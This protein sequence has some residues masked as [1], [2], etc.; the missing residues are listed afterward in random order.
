MPSQ[1][2]PRSERL[3][4]LIE[5]TETP[6]LVLAALAVALY[7]GDLAGFWAERH[8]TAVTTPLAAALDVVFVVDVVFKA[9]VLGR[10][11][12]KTGWFFIDLVSALPVV[13]T[14][15]G[16][17]AALRGLRFVRG[18]RVFRLLRSLRSLRALRALPGLRVPAAQADAPESATFHRAVTVAVAIYVALLLALVEAPIGDPRTAELY[19]VVGSL[20]GTALVLAIVRYQLPDVST[21]QVRTLLNVALPE[22]VAGRLMKD[23]DAYGHS[24]RGPATVVFC[25]LSGFTASVEA[26][27]GDLDAL[28]KN[29][30]AC[31]DAVVAVHLEHDLIVDK[32]IGDAVMS[33]RGGDMVEGDPEDHACRVVRASVQSASA[34]ARVQNPWFRTMKIGGAS[35]PDILIGTFGTSRRLSYTV[36]GDRVNLASRLE[37][38][39]G[40]FGVA[41]LFDE[42]TRDLA[43]DCEGIAWRR[44]GRIRVQGKQE[45]ITVF[46]ALDAASDTGW[47]AAYEAAVDRFEARDFAAAR[48]GFEVALAARGGEDGPSRVFVG[49][50]ERLARDGVPAGWEPILQ[51][52]K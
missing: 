47:V 3:P 29:L 17:P 34:L 22:Q 6:V 46:E 20:L 42:T 48:A 30:E 32:F 41:N 31:L 14:I 8:L 5:R 50:C 35:A 7:I 52:K 18:M 27:G 1:T 40:K 51:T 11:Y 16:A 21:Q 39:C 4:K 13:A 49:E 28:K 2:A 33:F 24:V 43:R 37:G 36:L 25:D 15:G 19:L 23:P 45:P 12:L 10:A 9:A 26:L 44:V 38:Q